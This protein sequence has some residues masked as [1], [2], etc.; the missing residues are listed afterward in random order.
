MKDEYY[1]QIVTRKTSKAMLAGVVLAV[2]ITILLFGV[3]ILYLGV[4][5]FI[6]VAWLL[7]IIR[8]FIY[9]RIHVEYEY[10][11][12]NRNLE[13]AAIY[14]KE[15]RRNRIYLNLDKIEMMAPLGSS[16]LTNSH[17]DHSYDFS[18][19]LG[20]ADSYAII[21]N[22]DQKVLQIIFDPDQEILNRICQVIKTRCY[23]H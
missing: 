6:A 11:L 17:P 1:E 20:T 8:F 19:G 10:M 14:N 12:L 23:F 22:R 16:V 9:P 21:V 3:G 5:A 4:L 7:V 15:K 13:I 18:S 2:V